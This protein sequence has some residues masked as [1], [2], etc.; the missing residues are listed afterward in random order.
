VISL[1]EVSA[2]GHAARQA[3]PGAVQRVID[4][5]GPDSLA[6]L[7]YT[8]GTTGK[9]KGVELT[10]RSWTYMGVAMESWDPLEPDDVQYLWLPLAHVFGKCLIAV[11]MT[12]GFPS[13]VDGRVDR[14][15]T[16]LSE[17]HP[18]FM[19]GVPRI[20][21]KVRAKVIT[22]GG[23]AGRISAWAFD[24][25]SRSAPYRLDGSPMP[26]GLAIKQ[27]IA[28]RLVFSKLKQTMG[29][30]IRMMV[31]GG[32]KLSPQVQRWFFAAGI[33]V[34]EGYGATETSAIA[35]FNVP[36]KG[37]FGPRFGTVGPVCPGCE[38]KL[39]ED[40]EVLVSGPIVA[41]G[42]HEMPEKTAETFA[43]GWYHTGDIGHFDEDGYLVVTERK[44]DL[45]KT[46]GGKYI[47]PQKVE[48]TLMANCP[49]LSQAVVL[50]EGH[51]YAVALLT[52]DRDALFQWAEN[53]GHAGESYET[54]SQLPEIRNSIQ[55][56]V[57]RANTHLDRWETVKRFAILDHQLDE[58]IGMVTESQ[59]V[60]RDQVRAEYRET[61]AALYADEQTASREG[62]AQ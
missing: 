34:V 26:K 11:Q 4:A 41:R 13:A 42:Y 54:L 52:L 30:R 23:L 49:Y 35:F 22:S 29:G 21:E 5:T 12:I 19:C 48:T 2:K 55:R 45:I 31:C 16:G 62:P 59:K 58:V 25:G 37:R 46:S 60:R 20:F 24:V 10:H 33:P 1:A 47:A 17:V 14:I 18:T 28:E 61:I 3:D 40:G 43:D 56:F 50:G 32:A 8:S 9:P 38:A 27:A 6:T 39:A 53:H 44:R 7:I 36:K 51:K 15:V 57:D